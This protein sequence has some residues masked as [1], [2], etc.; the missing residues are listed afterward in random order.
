MGVKTPLT[1]KEAQK[2]FPHYHLSELIATHSGIM[3]TTYLT[4]NYVL[5]KYERDIDEQIK[6]EHKLLASLKKIGLNVP[7]HLA[8]SGDWHLYER[9][10]GKTPNHIQSYHI[11]ALARTLS[12]LHNYTYKKYSSIDII[13]DREVDTLLAYTKSHF[14][15]YYKKLSMLQQYK[16]QHDG[17]IH[18]DIFK[19]NTVFDKDKLG[20]FDFIDAG[21]GS[22]SFDI[23]VVLL[24]FN[25]QKH[26]PFFLNLFVNTYN[27]HAPKKQK[28]DT[29]IR[30]IEFAKSLYALK[31]I[32]REHSTRHAKE[33]LL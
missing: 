18:G 3:D 22:F 17:I 25:A 12:S 7:T 4:P 21:N 2:L 19:D 33:L 20:I 32:G 11:Q 24:S 5:K 26:H 6:D 27:Q 1:L 23:A 29:I 15:L 28:K 8:N 10:Q 31:R 13:Q 16:P 14:F 30:D 9:V